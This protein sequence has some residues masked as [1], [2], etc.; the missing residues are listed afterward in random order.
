[1]S[2]FAAVPLEN[3]ARALAISQLF[4]AMIGSDFESKD[5][6]IKQ[7]RGRSRDVVIITFSN[8]IRICLGYDWP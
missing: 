1:M 5:F 2:V 7:G 6:L 4:L 8:E 3:L